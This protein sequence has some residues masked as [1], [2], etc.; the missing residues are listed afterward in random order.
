MTV[1]VDTATGYAKVT[2][3]TENGKK[4]EGGSSKEAVNQ[5]GIDFTSSLAVV[6]ALLFV[7]AFGVFMIR[8]DSRTSR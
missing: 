2:V 8:K 4:T 6:A 5:T 1:S 7:F 3:T